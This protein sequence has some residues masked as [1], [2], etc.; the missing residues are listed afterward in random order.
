MPVLGQHV[1]LV[2]EFLQQLLT[3]VGI[4]HLLYRYL[5]LEITAT[6]DG[7]EAPHR[8]L[9]SNLQVRQ[10]QHQ[11][12]IHRLPFR[13]TLHRLHLI[14]SRSACSSG[15]VGPEARLPPLFLLLRLLRLFLFDQPTRGL[16]LPNTTRLDCPSA[17]EAVGEGL[18]EVVSELERCQPFEL[19]VERITLQGQGRQERDL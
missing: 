8:Y 9:F 16:V 6:M 10:L 1:D 17:L 5:Q 4:E 15:Q 12:P 11:H 2:V 14:L 7:A 19:L 18:L 3:D 13:L